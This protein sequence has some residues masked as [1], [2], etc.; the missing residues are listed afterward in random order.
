HVRKKKKSSKICS[1]SSR[2]T[3]RS[4]RAVVSKLE[5]WGRSPA[6]PARRAPPFHQ[7]HHDSG[8]IEAA[9]KIGAGDATPHAQVLGISAR[10][11]LAARGTSTHWKEGARWD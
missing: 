2:G 3:A 11:Q 7:R 4:V 6:T 1:F 8:A 9:A 10:P 5:K